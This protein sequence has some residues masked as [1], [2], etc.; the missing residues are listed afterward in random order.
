MS[1]HLTLL[2]VVEALIGKP[3]AVGEI[4][5]VHPKAPY[6]WR[7][8]NGRREAGDIPYAAHMRALLAHSAAHRLGLTADHLIWGAE[9][10]E[11]QAILAARASHPDTQIVRAAE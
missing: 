11:V 9:E 6:H 7:E 1:N 5:H 10:A 8:R 4:V 2:D 3:E